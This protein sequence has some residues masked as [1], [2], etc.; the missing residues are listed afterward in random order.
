MGWSTALTG[1]VGC[2]EQQDGKKIEEKKYSPLFF[3]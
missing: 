2:A 3:R 1:C